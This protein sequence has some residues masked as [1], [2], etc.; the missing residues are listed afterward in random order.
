MTYANPKLVLDS[1]TLQAG[2]VAWRSPSN[3]A[4]V[5][6]WGKHGR[7]LPRNANLS[8]TLNAAHT[9]TRIHYRRGGGQQVELEFYFEGQPNEAFGKKVH[10]Y[11][12]SITEIFPF[13][14]QLHLTVHSH[15]S[16]PHSAGIASSASAM[17]ALALCLCS[18]EQ[19]LFGTLDTELAF[20]QKASYVARLGSGSAC[21]SV[22]G[23]AAV[24]GKHME[25]SDS[26]D[27]YAVP[28]GESLH[29]VFRSFR[30]S[31]LIVSQDEKSVSSRAGHALMEENRYAQDRYQQAGQRM[32]RLLPALRRGDVK[33]VGEIIEA[34]ALTLHAL[35]MASTPPYLLLQ[36]NTI[37]VINELWAWRKD[38]S[39]PLYFSLDA[40]PNL[41]LLYPKSETE[42]VGSFIQSQLRSYA[43]DGKIIEDRVGAGPLQ[44]A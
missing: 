18:L 42:R 26:S 17:S 23:G 31:I 15:N 27:E 43:A 40:G 35:M 39:V 24:W 6:Y 44:L 22:Y 30:N 36:P 41:H 2:E 4:L 10:D 9:E 11:L 25:L 13:L 8:F 20:R 16:F 33:T 1:T 28:F 32:Q 3:I 5:K 37:A 34:E 29:D 12:S 38:S 7:Q 19:R 21:R 14:R